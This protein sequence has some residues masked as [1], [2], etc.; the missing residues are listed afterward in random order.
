MPDKMEEKKLHIFVDYIFV[1]IAAAGALCVAMWLHF[2][3]QGAGTG[4]SIMDVM[5]DAAVMLDREGRIADINPPACA[6][7]GLCREEALMR[8]AG[9]LLSCSLGIEGGALEQSFYPFSISSGDGSLSHYIMQ[10]T[11]I[12]ASA[13]NSEG[14]L[15][16]MRDVTKMRDTQRALD[17]I[18]K[19]DRATGLPNGAYLMSCLEEMMSGAAADTAFAVIMLCADTGLDS[20]AVFSITD[21]DFLISEVASR[22]RG[23]LREGSFLTR[24][25]SGELCIVIE[26]RGIQ[27]NDVLGD[28]KCIQSNLAKPILLFSRKLSASFSIGYVLGMNHDEDPQKLIG[29]AS[30]ALSVARTK[31]PGSAVRYDSRMGAEIEHK[32]NLSQHIGDAVDNNEMYVEFQPLISQDGSVFGAECL[33]RWRHPQEGPI[34]PD[35]FIPIAEEKN[36]IHDLGLWVIEQACIELERLIK[37][38]IETVR[39][40]VNVSVLQLYD[41]AFSLKVESIMKRHGIPGSLL[42]FE[43]TESMALNYNQNVTTNIAEITRMGIR[44]SMDDFGMGCS[45][46]MYLTCLPLKTIKLDKSL[47]QNARTNEKCSAIINSVVLL[48]SELGIELIAECVETEEQHATLAEKG[49]RLF[50][51]WYFSRPLSNADFISFLKRYKGNALSR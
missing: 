11:P 1:I 48:C 46:L 20:G 26:G 37:M 14:R 27:E 32:F 42:E 40:A 44:V 47:V 45:S 25:G 43:I 23:C 13:G 8:S 29:K 6:L 3:K 36:L 17:F 2:R 19:H 34:P 15:I 12:G 18:D 16:L 41:G 33:L 28:I 30:I 22:I 21:M 5:P 10:S 50:Q 31:N 38:N 9:E 7:T 35:V 39:I 49:V 4:R 51:G 24:T